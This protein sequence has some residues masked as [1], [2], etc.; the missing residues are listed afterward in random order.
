MNRGYTGIVMAVM[1]DRGP[2]TNIG[3]TT[4]GVT[5]VTPGPPTD[6]VRAG[7]TGTEPGVTPEVPLDLPTETRL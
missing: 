4:G 5:G 2:V 6:M 1:R 3:G 7:S